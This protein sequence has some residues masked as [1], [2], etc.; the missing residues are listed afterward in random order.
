MTRRV[1]SLR[2]RAPDEALL[3]RGALLVEDALRTASLPESRRLVLLRR[4]DVGPIRPALSPAA[5]A[6]QIE[7][8]VAALGPAL[9]Y[10]DG[11]GADRAPGVFFA[12]AAEPYALLA[13]RTLA[14]RAAPEWFW[15]LAVPGWRPNSRP[16]PSEA[17]WL[18]ARAA[19]R[20]GP[21]AG[22][23]AVE[24]LRRRGALAALLAALDQAGGAE[25]LRAFAWEAPAEPAPADD[26][27]PALVAGEW[28]IPRWVARWGV[29]AAPSRWLAA[30][31]LAAERP[32][33]LAQPERLL[34]QAATL[35]RLGSEPQPATPA[36]PPTPATSAGQPNQLAGPVVGASAPISSAATALTSVD[37]PP[38]V[39]QRAW[40]GG[41]GLLL[42]L[43]VL[44]RL[45]MAALLRRAP[46]LAEGGLP[47][48]VLQALAERAG[49]PGTDPLR[50][51][52][53]VPASSAAPAAFALPAWSAL[54]QRPLRVQPLACGWQ[55]RSDE[56]G[57]LVLALRRCRPDRLKPARRPAP[58]GRGPRARPGRTEQLWA[59]LARSWVCAVGRWLERHAGLGLAELIARPGVLL[60]A[61]GHIEL[62]FA[63]EQAD[64]RIR[65][66]GLDIDPGWVAWLGR[67]IAFHYVADPSAA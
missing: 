42:T 66:A 55:A 65:R 31:A 28:Q 61:P 46:P 29:Q 20:Q 36:S 34:T 22:V 33:R 51:L 43:A 16:R 23:R 11:P 30:M 15:P 63:H 5:L 47:E 60:A 64:I 38:P 45:G 14:G 19:E 9:V 67:A 57:E 10:A 58:L 32:A 4:L 18:L 2:L 21:A 49:V 48:R 50:A 41:A 25:L 17:V 53:P 6:L 59:L 1:H 7:A 37:L 54:A 44:E 3:R 39:E 8:R 12:D 26:P 52:L 56:A 13:L 62:F 27:P 40:T 24:T 35:V